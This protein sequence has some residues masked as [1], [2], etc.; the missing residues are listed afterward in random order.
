VLADD[1]HL[2]REHA[3]EETLGELLHEQHVGKELVAVEAMSTTSGVALALSHRSCVF[4]KKCAS[5]T[6]VAAEQTSRSLALAME[7]NSFAGILTRFSK[8]CGH[9]KHHVEDKGVNRAL[10]HGH[11]HEG[12]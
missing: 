5:M 8:I 2:L 3:Q 10:D 7:K 1:V 4:E 12:G 9:H 11:R 6:V